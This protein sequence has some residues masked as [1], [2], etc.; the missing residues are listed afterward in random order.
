MVKTPASEL[1]VLYQY[2]VP[3][4]ELMEMKDAFYPGV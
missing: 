2:I 4:I 1:F 3:S